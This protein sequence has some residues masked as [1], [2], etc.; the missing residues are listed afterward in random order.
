ML[1]RD[2]GMVARG[3]CAG[4]AEPADTFHRA[5]RG[6]RRT[7]LCRSRVGEHMSRE[8]RQASIYR[9]PNRCRRTIGIDTAIK[10]PPDG[11]S[12]LITNDNVASAP[13]VMRLNIDFL[14]DLLP[15]SFLVGS[16]KPLPC[17]PHSQQFIRSRTSLR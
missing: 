17:I 6:R 2:S 12:V 11:Y 1:S 7:G 13:H 8:L 4:V 16:P 3:A 9:E 15:V 5:T 10:S 14:K